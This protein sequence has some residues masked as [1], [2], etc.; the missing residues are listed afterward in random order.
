[1]TEPSWLPF[2]AF[3]SQPEKEN[4]M[5]F[6]RLTTLQSFLAMA[7][8]FT[9]ADSLAVPTFA[10]IALNTID[11]VA[12]Q[13]E[14]GRQ[15]IV[16]GPI[17]CTAG[18]GVMLRVTVTQRSTGAVRQGHTRFTCT[19]TLQQWEVLVARHKKA[20]FADGAATAVAL[21]RTTAQGAPT[22][23]HLWLVEEAVAE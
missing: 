18:Y 7:L 1:M 19:D 3:N 2:S 10:G 9:S 21:A 14:S 16:T 8:V 23:A 17:A 5:F 4:L 13:I 20:A 6:Q 12:Y 22:D 11:T 15:I